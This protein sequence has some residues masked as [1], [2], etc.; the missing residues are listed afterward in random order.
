MSLIPL[1]TLS[2]GQNTSN[3]LSDVPL[4]RKD[5]V[6]I[7]HTVLDKNESFGK[8][9][10]KERF[11]EKFIRSDY[12]NVPENFHKVYKYRLSTVTTDGNDNET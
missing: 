3:S 4:A 1:I 10:I 2:F 6:F 7:I 11:I 12:V 8:N 9:H 5:T